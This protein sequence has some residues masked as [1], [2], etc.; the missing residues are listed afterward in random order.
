GEPLEL[1]R[2]A[3]RHEQRVEPRGIVAAGECRIESVLAFEDASRTGE[4][5]S[6]E[7][8][9]D[10]A[11]VSAPARM[12]AL[13]PRALAEVLDD[14]GGLAAADSER[15]HE[16]SLVE[17]VETA[18]GHRRCEARRERCG[19]EVARVEAARHGQPDAAHH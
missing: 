10:H 18:G 15:V 14:A 7:E 17:A 2:L 9:S 19:M 3:E 16:L 8:G 4:P 12:H 13:G 11:A 5:V 6:S 1:P